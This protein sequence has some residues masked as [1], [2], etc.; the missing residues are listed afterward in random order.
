MDWFGTIPRIDI[1]RA[2]LMRLFPVT[3]LPKKM[4]KLCWLGLT[5]PHRISERSD[6]KQ[7]IRSGVEPANGNR[8][9]V[10]GVE[11]PSPELSVGLLRAQPMI[12]FG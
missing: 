10:G 3:A 7:A 11:P 12:D 4:L 5:K 2:S 8:V 6:T 1:W 9:E